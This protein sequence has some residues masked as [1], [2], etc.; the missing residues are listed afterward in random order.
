M[1]GPGVHG[2]AAIAD[3]L[4]RIRAGDADELV[5]GR[6]ARWAGQVDGRGACHLPDGVVRFVRSGL[7]LF[8]QDVEDHRRHGPCTA[9]ARPAVLE[10]F[11]AVGVAA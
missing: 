7:A 4:R 5:A 6:V 10:T 2:L 3:A 9:C 8:A 11:G 1:C